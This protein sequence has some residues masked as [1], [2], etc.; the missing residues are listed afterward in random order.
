MSK[1]WL[2]VHVAGDAV[3]IVCAAV[4]HTGPITILADET[5]KLQ[6]GDRSKAFRTMYT[7]LAD[8]ANEQKIDQVVIKESAISLGGMK[9]AHLQAAELRGVTICALASACDVKQVA[10]AAI[11]RNFGERKADEYIKDDGFWK[12]NLTGAPMRSGSR[13]AA[14]LILASR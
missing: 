13:E 4:D 3:T 14:M 1:T 2:G 8:Y 9:K 11:S 10:K 6:S 7:R 12:D 5:W